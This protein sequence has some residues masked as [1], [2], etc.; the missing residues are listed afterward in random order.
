MRLTEIFLAVAVVV[1]TSTDSL[2]AA[3]ASTQPGDHGATDKNRVLLSDVD[4]KKV[5]LKHLG[6]D[7]EK[8]AAVH[9]PSIFSKGPIRGTFMK[10]R[11]YLLK[12]KSKTKWANQR[13][14]G[15]KIPS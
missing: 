8:R 4:Q 6:T 2:A 12:I 3:T 10:L 13:R 14:R 9:F 1:L 5:G 15:L 7:H 11:S